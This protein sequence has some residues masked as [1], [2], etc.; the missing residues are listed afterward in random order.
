MPRPPLPIGTWGRIRTQVVK[1]NEKGKAVSHRAQ[2]KYRDHDGQTRLVSAFGKTKTAAETNLLKKLKERAKTSLAGQ[3]TAMHKIRHA[4]ELWETKF[5]DL[6]AEGQRSPSSLDTYRRS[7]KNHLLPAL[8]E[9]RIGEASTPRIDSVVSEIKK[10]AGA[11]TARTCR[12]IISSVMGLAVRY[13]AINVNP[14]REVDRI[15][16]N[17]KKLPR[18][19][20]AEEVRLLRKQLGN[21]E[22]AVRADLPDLVTFMLGTGVRIGEA[23][24]VLWSQVDLETGKIKITH[25]IVRVNGEGLLRK[26][27]KSRAG[28]RELGLPNWALAVL[29]A[30]FAAGIRL[31]EPIFADAL[32]GFRDPSNVRR[33]LREALAPVGSTA[34]RDLGHSLR[35]ARRET[36]MTRKE[37][38]RALGWPESK[39]ELIET[40]RIKVDRQLA[41][42]LLRTY[43]IQLEECAAFSPR[44]MRQPNRHPQ[45]PSPGSPLTPSAKPQPPSSTTTA[46]P[47]AKSPTTS[48]TPASL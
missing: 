47:P 38:A 34:R 6:V 8:G 30:R 35:A 14:V 16:H 24:A 43:D 22:R 10:R 18:A 32:G 23:L 44:S 7:I 5:A 27:T 48:A 25:T 2:A 46:N 42:P 15:E 11:P 3:L 17:A 4:I 29:R 20:N 39:I 31:D 36:G 21:D 1:T 41:T 9:V 12:S 37:V 26:I 28:Q 13:G 45:T 19:L 40:G 33:S